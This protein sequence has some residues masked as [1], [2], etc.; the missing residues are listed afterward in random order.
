MG[1]IELDKGSKLPIY[2]QIAQQ[3]KIYIENKGLQEGAVIPT[4]RELCQAFSVS[5]MT[6]RQAVEVLVGEGLLN[7]Q[8][9]RGTFVSAPKACQQLTKLSSFT[10]DTL[11]RG[12]VPTSR[13]ISCQAM[14]ASPLVAEK[15]NVETGEVVVQLARVRY[16]NGQPQGHEKAN[17]LYSVASPLLTMNL[18]NSSLYKTLQDVC[19][20]ELLRASQRI[21][22]KICADKICRYLN[23]PVGSMVFNLQRTTYSS[24]EKAF[25]YTE[26]NYRTDKI[27]FNVE[28]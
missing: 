24:K 6:V 8:R 1:P 13:I 17:L 15:L 23:V 4:E 14:P 28:L 26:A 22:A 3:I 21:E 5:R 16:A 27:C 11:A 25:E 10:N 12:M 19:G 9:G 7:R 2:Y 18:A 20:L